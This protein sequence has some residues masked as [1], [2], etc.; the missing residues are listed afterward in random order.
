MNAT[1]E[2][3]SLTAW[4]A[5]ANEFDQSRAAMSAGTMDAVTFWRLYQRVCSYSSFFSAPNA[6]RF[7]SI[8]TKLNDCVVMYR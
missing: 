5:I 8:M 4:Q 3:K 2:T 6:G 1:A 7:T